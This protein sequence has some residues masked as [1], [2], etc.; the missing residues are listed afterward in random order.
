MA[1]LSDE[2][3]KKIAEA[4]KRSW[5]LRRTRMAAKATAEGKTATKGTVAAKP[6]GKGRQPLSAAAKRRIAAAVKRSWASRR[7]A[8]RA[9]SPAKDGRGSAGAGILAS[10]QQASQ[11]LRAL[12]L[13]D[14]RPLAGRKDAAAQLEDL[15]G[16]ASD[17]RRMI[18]K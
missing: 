1:K 8:G 10:I 2:A 3:K 18:A 14:L 6:A 16:L 5:A 11:A 9:E 4:V 7:R 12:T 15:A 13:D 17:L